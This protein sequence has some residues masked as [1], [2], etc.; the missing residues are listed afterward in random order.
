MIYTLDSCIKSLIKLWRKIVDP[1]GT[2]TSQ[3]KRYTQKN[4]YAIILIKK[5][6][7]W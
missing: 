1:T 5:E 4:K 2:T 7:P 6:V 3:F